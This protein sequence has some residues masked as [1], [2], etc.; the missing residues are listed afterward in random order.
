MAI[1]WPAPKDPND[2]K[3]YA[4]DWSPKLPDGDI[5]IGSEWFVVDETQSL[6]IDSSS[7]TDTL[8]TVWLS[9]GDES[10]A[11]EVLNRVTTQ[12]GRQY[13]Q[14]MKLKIKTL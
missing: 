14:T 10:S 7:F 3:D 11:V 12:G 5:L 6:V 4:L 2:I 13:D 8:S 1:S 9:E